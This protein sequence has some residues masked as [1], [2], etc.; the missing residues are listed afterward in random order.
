MFQSA[1]MLFHN[2]RA[3]GSL[4]DAEALK[5]VQHVNCFRQCILLVPL[6]IESQLGGLGIADADT[7]MM[8]VGNLLHDVGKGSILESDS[9]WR[10]LALLLHLRNGLHRLFLGRADR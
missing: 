10:L 6:E 7:D 3:I 4:H 8:I 9:D 2:E 1:R 5:P